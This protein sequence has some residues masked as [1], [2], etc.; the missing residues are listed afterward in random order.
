MLDL[1]RDFSSTGPRGPARLIAADVNHACGRRPKPCETRPMPAAL[2]LIF[3][4]SGAS[5]L[6]F[7][8]LWFR[9]AGL[10]LGNSVWSAS[11]VLAAFMGGLALGNGLA[12]RLGGRIAR[13]I[14]LYAGLEILIGASGAAV[15]LVL[16]AFPSLLGPLFTGMTEAPW[17]LNGARLAVAFAVLLLP[18][19]AMGLTLPI[20]TEAMSRIDTNFGSIVGRLYGWNTLGATVGAIS[21]ELVLVKF[22]GITGSG[23]FALA[24]N[25]TAALLASRLSKQR[26]PD[27]SAWTPGARRGLLRLDTRSY[28]YLAVAFCSGGVMLAL[29]VVWFRFLQL[30]YPGTGLVFAIMLGVVLCGIA[31]GGLVAAALYRRS[32]RA[33]EWLR[34][35]LALSGAAV[36]LTY[37]G[38]DLFTIRQI[39]RGTQLGYFVGLALFLMLPVATLSGMS[40]TMTARGLRNAMRSP[41]EAAGVATLCNTVGAMLGSLC[42]G[43]VLLPLLG[44][45]RSLFVLAIAYVGS[46]LLAPPAPTERRRVGVTGHAGVVACL[47]CLVVFPFGLMERSFF[48][49]AERSFPGYELVATR[50]SLTETARYYVSTAYDEPHAYRL[51]TNGHSMSG[52]MLLGKRYMKLYVYLPVALRERMSDALLISYG[53]GSTAKALTDTRSLERIDVVDVSRDVIEMNR[54]VY[55]GD[56]SPLADERVHVHIEDG[57]FFLNTTHNTYDL[58]T[59]EPP[60]PK[61]AGIASLYSQEY[62]ELMREKLNAGGYATYWLPVY[63]LT[64]LDTLAIIRAFCNAFDDCSLWS[65]AG[66]EWMLMGSNGAAARVSLDH[67]AAQ[68]KDPIVGPEMIGLGFEDPA[69]M[70]S[71]F[72]AD[73]D[74]LAAISARVPPV[75]DDHPLRISSSSV[76]YD[77]RVPFYAELADEHDRRER[78]RQSDFVRRL[79]PEELVAATEPFFAYERMIKNYFVAGRYAERGDPHT[80]EAID[81]LL[82]NT[83]L[84]S[85]PL[86]L[87]GSDYVVQDIVDRARGRGKDRAEFDLELAFRAVI[88]RDYESAVLHIERYFERAEAPELGAQSLRLYLLAKA[89]RLDEAL[90]AIDALSP[91]EAEAQRATG[92]LPWFVD[93]FTSER[94]ASTH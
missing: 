73:A 90:S 41:A 92:F 50:E 91:G 78:F 77:A 85:L 38:F 2:V 86:W 22:L 51:A 88:E 56:D 40:F 52:T 12:A 27:A 65:G 10:S 16:P 74:R 60:P 71:L 72:I 26:E 15:V 37:A 81:D 62:F 42:G 28:R 94:A 63:Q 68:W 83:K 89:N 35:V 67:F 21:T 61:L 30:S 3:F 24:L 75:T 84:T 1:L 39:E 17:L 55:P 58:I 46:A 59:S 25:F 29:E 53:V 76:D 20:L 45:E 64:P 33:H 4:L 47:C 57:R 43:F 11:L 32:E 23:L 44:M 82:T 14:R 31:L 70:G 69:Q 93:R 13:P 87:L 36:V 9:L 6:V 7:E 5:A 54:I 8:A 48:K 66:L 80:W 79:W 18:A 49:I 19:T 34:P